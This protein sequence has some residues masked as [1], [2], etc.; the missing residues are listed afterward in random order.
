MKPKSLF[1]VTILVFVCV[2]GFAQDK[3]GGKWQT[4]A[5]K[6]NR[7]PEQNQFQVEAVRLDLKIQGDM[8]SGAVDEIGAGAPL[9]ITDGE[10]TGW[11]L[12][13]KTTRTLPSGATVSYIWRGE[14]INDN[15]LS[16]SRVLSQAG[17]YAPGAKGGGGFAGG[18]P[19]DPGPAPRPRPLI[20]H[21][22][23]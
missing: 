7:P 13:F 20:F 23:P 6:A 11:A 5:A 15:T 2:A 16:L 19:V 21:R 4:D 22:M 18:A 8:V 10:I 3:F 12:S 17:R 1:A 9:T 14:L